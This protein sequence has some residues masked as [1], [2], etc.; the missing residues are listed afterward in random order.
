MRVFIFLL[1]N[2]NKAKEKE[3]LRDAERKRERNRKNEWKKVGKIH[4]NEKNEETE[5]VEEGEDDDKEGEEEDEID[6][7]QHYYS[8][9]S[10]LSPMRKSTWT[11][12]I[13]P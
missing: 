13:K 11:P 7:C 2:M 8:N 10:I 3:C 12:Q 4:Q 6:F 5:K 9:D 1:E